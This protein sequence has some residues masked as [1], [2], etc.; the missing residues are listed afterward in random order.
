MIDLQHLRAFAAITDAGGVTQAAGR[1][2]LS[3]PALTRQLQAL[4]ATLGVPLFERSGRRLRLTTAGAD[5]LM[6]S[7]RVIDEAN[8]LGE[9]ARALAG[10]EAGV[11]RIGATPPMIEAI[12]AGFL[13]MARSRYPAIEVRIVEDGG[14]SLIARLERGEIELAYV[15][16][17][18]RFAGELLYPVHVVAAVGEHDRLARLRQVEVRALAGAGLIAL[19]RGFGSRE[20]FEA[21]CSAAGVR[22]TILLESSSH[23]AIL[24]LA[25][26]GYGIGILPSAMIVPDAGLK[27][28]PIV[29]GGAPI[30]R[31]TMLA[32]DRRR[33]LAPFALTFAGELASFAR[34]NHPGRALQRR[35]GGIPR[36]ALP[37]ATVR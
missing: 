28:I 34:A 11:I 35:V 33:F 36:P 20:W 14:E 3:Q 10:G 15:P 4:E 9:R 5:L 29:S 17:N 31:W 37:H 16:A 6:R 19:Q 7:R 26:A 32:T 12:L 25:R 2:N 18:D 30:G 13:P 22:P 1:L 23:N 27:L 8:A 24:G 21:A